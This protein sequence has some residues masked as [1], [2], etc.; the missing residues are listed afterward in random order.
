LAK[1]K[2]SI[3]DTQVMCIIGTEYL[4]TLRDLAL[5]PERPRY[6]QL[7]DKGHEALSH[8]WNLLDTSVKSAVLDRGIGIQRETLSKYLNDREHRFQ[9]NKIEGVFDHIN[10]QL[11]ARGLTRDELRPFDEENYCFPY[12]K[13]KINSCVS[14][15][16][17]R[18]RISLEQQISEILNTL[19]CRVQEE[20]FLTSWNHRKYAGIFLIKTKNLLLQ[21]WLVKR[22]AYRASSIKDGKRI[23]KFSTI[24]INRFHRMCCDSNALLTAIGDEFSLKGSRQ[25]IIQEICKQ[26]ST[27]PII[28]SLHG[29][30]TLMPEVQGSLFEFWTELSKKYLIGNSINYRGGLVLFLTD[31]LDSSLNI[32]ISSDIFVELDPLK[33][34]PESDISVWIREHYEILKHVNEIRIDSRIED[35]DFNEFIKGL[36]LWDENPENILSNICREFLGSTTSLIEPYWMSL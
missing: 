4:K 25:L 10:Q 1:R 21:R 35:D 32:N 20:A 22:L 34:I 15:D 13:P 24:T 14:K 28:L 31:D 11:E 23:A 6:Y 33:C 7:S 26:A 3:I 30:N 27:Q 5:K 18:L 16:A 8:L 17:P 29:L 12:K 2:V 9:L 19:D 36:K